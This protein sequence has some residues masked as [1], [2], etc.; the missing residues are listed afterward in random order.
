MKYFISMSSIKI[1]T[2]SSPDPIPI[3][4]RPYIPGYGIATDSNNLI[5]W[6]TVR[7]WMLEP[8]NYWISTTRK[9]GNPHAVPVW[10]I[11]QDATDTFF[12]GG[13]PT[14]KTKNMEN[15]P[16]VVVHT[17]SGTHMVIIEG[18][19]KE[20]PET[21]QSK[22][23]DAYEI[24]YNIRH[25]PKVLWVKMKKVFAWNGEDYANTPT[26]WRFE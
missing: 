1:E 20:I 22:I 14:Q 24:K 13:G 4:D 7:S 15:N 9:S 25:G 11:W 21:W 6:E 17:E 3:P 8:K 19:V 12:F 16:N 5:T 26:R 18:I 23:D 10:G 2:P